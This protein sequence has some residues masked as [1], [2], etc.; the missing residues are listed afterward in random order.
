MGIPGS[1]AEQCLHHTGRVRRRSS[2]SLWR[3]GEVLLHCSLIGQM[4]Q[5]PCEEVNHSTCQ[6]RNPGGNQTLPYFIPS[7]APAAGGWMR[8]RRPEAARKAPPALELLS[9][10]H[11]SSCHHLSGVRRGLRRR[12]RHGG[13]RRRRIHL[14]RMDRC[15]HTSLEGQKQLGLGILFTRPA[16]FK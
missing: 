4:P 14:P 13:Q 2:S 7:S 9:P 6:H 11:S 5:H 3:G 8:R 10:A 16:L 15:L 1:L 12:P